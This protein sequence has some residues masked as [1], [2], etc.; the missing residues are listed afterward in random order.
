MT[1]TEY[2]AQ[3]D[4][5]KMPHVVLTEGEYQVWHTAGVSPNRFTHVSI[6]GIGNYVI[7]EGDTNLF[8]QNEFGYPKSSSCFHLEKPLEDLIHYERVG[9]S[10]NPSKS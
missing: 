10:Y 7:K 3:T 2:L 8:T 1:L 9:D 6:N 4:P 5:V